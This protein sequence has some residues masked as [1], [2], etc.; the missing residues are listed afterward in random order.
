MQVTLLDHRSEGV[1]DFMKL[2]SDTGNSHSI[3]GRQAYMGLTQRNRATVLE[4]R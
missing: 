2:P 4:W 3:G 1:A